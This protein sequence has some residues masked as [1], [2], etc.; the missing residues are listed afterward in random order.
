VFHAQAGSKRH[1]G[2]PVE[3]SFI[4]LDYLR[5]RHSEIVGFIATPELSANVREPINLRFSAMINDNI[6]AT[7]E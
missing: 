7:G 1:L 3:I 2:V 5:E 6:A 4:Y